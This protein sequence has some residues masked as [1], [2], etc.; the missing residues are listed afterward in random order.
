M[1]IY[2]EGC[3]SPQRN[4]ERHCLNCGKSFGSS[5]LVIPMGVLLALVVPALVLASGQKVDHVFVSKIVFWY[6]LP[7]AVM[8]AFLYD[9][10][11]KRRAIYFCGGVAVIL[12]SLF[13]L[14]RT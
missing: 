11:P 1:Q 8:T 7:V 6:C 9:Y 4:A 13:V 10:H 14:L 3:S 2:C 12:G 5:W